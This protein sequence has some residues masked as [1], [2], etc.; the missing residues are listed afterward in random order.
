[1]GPLTP[2]KPNKITCSLNC[3]DYEHVYDIYAFKIRLFFYHIMVT[4]IIVLFSEKVE[5][6]TDCI[7]F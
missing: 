4:Y 5:V 1:M 6:M 7:P 2:Y 3:I